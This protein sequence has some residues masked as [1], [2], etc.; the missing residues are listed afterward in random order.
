MYGLGWWIPA[1]ANTPSPKQVYRNRGVGEEERVQAA[2]TYTL[3]LAQVDSE[4]AR[5]R[6]EGERERTANR[7]FAVPLTPRM[8]LLSLLL[9][10]AAE[11]QTD[12]GTATQRSLLPLLFDD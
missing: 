5:I 6:R 2:H 3:T 9:L 7:S 12:G 8:V 11:R 10:A 4:S 1:A